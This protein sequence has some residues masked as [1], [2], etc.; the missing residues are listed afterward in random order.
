MTRLAGRALILAAAICVGLPALQVVRAQPAPSGHEHELVEGKR[1]FRKA[2]AGCHKWHG[3]G[4]GGYGGAA[5]SLRQT[6]L[7][8][9]QIIETATCGRPGTGMP[10]FGRNAYDS[11]KCYGL[12]RQQLGK[13]MPIEAPVFLRPQ[14][15][16]AI[17]DYVLA[18]V[19]GKGDPNYAQCIDFFGNGSR[20][21]DVYEAAAQTRRGRIALAEGMMDFAFRGAGGLAAAGLIVGIAA[22]SGNARAA[23]R[24]DIRQFRV[25][26][27]VSELP[28]KGYVDF[29]CAADPTHKIAGWAE[30]KQCP[31]DAAGLHEVRFHYDN[32]GNP[33]A[34]VNE[35]YRG[36]RVAGHP[37][38]ISLL[39]GNDARV[40]AIRIDTDPH[41]RFYM[42]KKAFLLGNQVKERFGEQ[43]WVCKHGSPTADEQPVGGMFIKQHCEKTLPGRHLI[44]DER[45][46]RDPN[47]SLKDFTGGTQLLIERTG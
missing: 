11:N 4:G 7:S 1:L 22:A 35:G 26:M 47:K 14:E 23:E 16:G 29:T 3:N 39:I 17:V 20:V 21:C 19:K 9:E 30:Y 36:T 18:K 38:L 33:V 40:D 46:Y 15:I 32:S 2:C 42:R 31:A 13:M 34:R 44:L 37:V 45:L 25:G 24:N 41:A 12:T 27:L 8:R 5:L 6:H 43:G 28:A 10:Y